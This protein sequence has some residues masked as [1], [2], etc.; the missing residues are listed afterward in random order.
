M[1]ILSGM[2]GSKSWFRATALVLSLGAAWA[3]AGAGQ[4][5]A[6]LASAIQKVMDRP[7]FRHA[8]FGIKFYALDT[9]TVLYAHDADKLFVPAS[10]TKIL[11]EGAL[12]AHLGSDYRFHT[13]IFHTGTID[14]K[15]HLKG[16]LVLVAGGDPNLSNRIRADNTLA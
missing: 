8:N 6:G 12:L 3:S 15:G 13:R 1:R 9:G 14:K 2:G 5:T 11:S 16:D 7:Q 4:Q 10:T